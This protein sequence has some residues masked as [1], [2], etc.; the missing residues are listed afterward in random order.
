[1][2]SL[3]SQVFIRVMINYQVRYVYSHQ[4]GVHQVGVHQVGVSL[5]R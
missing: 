3:I 4:V 2:V 5:V 1:V